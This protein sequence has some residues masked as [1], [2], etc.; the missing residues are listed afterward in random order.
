[1]TPEETLKASIASLCAHPNSSE[2][3]ADGM[4]DAIADYVVG[5]PAGGSIYAEYANRGA[6]P[7][8]G[9]LNKIYVALDTGASYRWDGDSYEPLASAGPIAHDSTSGINSG[10]IQ[11][12]TSAQK[13]DL[14]DG[15]DSSAHYHASDRT[16]ATAAVATHVAAPNPHAQYLLATEK[17]AANG[18]CELDGVGYVPL[19]RIPIGLLGAM[20]YQAT[21]DASTNTPTLPA[22]PD[23]TTKG[24]FW[25]VCVKGTYGDHEYNPFDLIISNGT[26]WDWVDNSEVISTVFGRVGAITAQA[27]DYNAGQV[28][29]TPAGGV[30]ATNVQAAIAELDTEKQA[31]IPTGTALQYYRGDKVWA[32]LDKAAVGLGNVDNTSDANKPISTA[33]Q[34]ALDAKSPL[35]TTLTDNAGSSTLPVTASGT[36]VSKIQALRDNAK[37][38]LA[39]NTD[40]TQSALN[41]GASKTSPVDADVIPLLDSADSS[42]IK[43]LSWANVKA[44]LK[45]Y[46]DGIYS[47][48]T[49]GTTDTTAYR[50][51][52]GKTAY[53]HSQLTAS[54]P[55][56]TT[57]AQVGLGNVD[58]TS[59]ADKPVSTATASAL[60]AKLARDGS[61]TMTGDLFFSGVSDTAIRQICFNMAYSDYAR[62]AVGGT[63]DN[64]GFLEFATADDGTEPI[65]VRQYT[66]GFATVNRTATLLDGSG[67]TS[68]P[69]TVT[70]PA[71]SG[72]LSG[73]A[74]TAT[75]LANAR[76]IALTGDVAGSGS[77][78]GSGNLNI[79]TT[80][81]RIGQGY[82]SAGNYTLPAGA[83]IGYRVLVSGTDNMYNGDY[84]GLVYRSSDAY[85]IDP[86]HMSPGYG[87]TP[88]Q[89]ALYSAK[90]FTK[91]EGGRWLAESVN[92]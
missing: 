29:F 4:G 37:Y 85:I 13:A 49:L 40:S 73:N 30:A 79:A 72:N 36:L 20:R 53:D 51:D 35:N 60:G 33:T 17:G 59:D 15:G 83:P 84:S 27:G 47:T 28:T 48:L 32:T 31:S 61:Q 58:N 8:T 10:N 2:E 23:A 38:L 76:T 69:G 5:G 43:K 88:I 87:S 44:T 3:Y 78:D 25:K 46:F 56:G 12:L 68:F 18:L 16:F 89:G 92:Y 1:M 82:L 19:A 52:R 24:M 50:G 26:S 22:L 90:W 41:A 9:T 39:L 74:A 70:A 21:W 65:Y 66:G 75:K 71:F 54:N 45:A 14:T 62:I 6:F 67:N 57:K 77:F 42:A 64:A 86:G 80:V 34:S 91:I 63:A 81:S 55:H 11:H 7:G